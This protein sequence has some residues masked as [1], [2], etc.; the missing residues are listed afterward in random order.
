MLM[1]P[2]NGP[3]YDSEQMRAVNTHDILQRQQP[4]TLGTWIVAVLLVAAAIAWAALVVT[5]SHHT[6]ARPPASASALTRNR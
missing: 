1:P 3:H 6:S 5:H 2:P 4:A